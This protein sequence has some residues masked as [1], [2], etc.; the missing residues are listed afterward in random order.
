MELELDRGLADERKQR[1]EARELLLA[2]PREEIRARSISWNT[3]SERSALR[4]DEIFIHKLTRLLDI[5]K[6]YEAQGWDTTGILQS[7][8]HVGPTVAKP[9]GFPYNFPEYRVPLSRWSDRIVLRLHADVC[10]YYGKIVSWPHLE[11]DPR[12]EP[13]K[14]WEMFLANNELRGPVVISIFALFYHEST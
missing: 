3:L 11:P 7:P 9:I 12:Y 5:K 10:R 2:I 4:S 8:T 6:A 13:E 14:H 1:L